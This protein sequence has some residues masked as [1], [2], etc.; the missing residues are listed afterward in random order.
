VVL[1]IFPS[2]FARLTAIYDYSEGSC[3]DRGQETREKTLLKLK[4]AAV[5]GGRFT[6]LV[7]KRR[8]RDTISEKSLLSKL[9]VVAFFLVFALGM[10]QINGGGVKT[11]R[12]LMV[13]NINHLFTFQSRDDLKSSA[14][15]VWAK[16]NFG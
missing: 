6:Q 15:R 16:E 7:L 13:G 14:F 8:R 9:F 10:I 3:E 11:K 2:L 5:A 12:G 4:Q 1:F